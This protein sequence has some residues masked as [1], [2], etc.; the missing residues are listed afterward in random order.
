FR[1]NYI[2][3]AM[4]VPPGE[5]EIIFKF[6]LKSYKTGQRVGFISSI[7]FMFIIIVS[8]GFQLKGKIK[9]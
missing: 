4:N 2:L 9:A 1:S 8:A 5:H 6:D 7:L 3:R